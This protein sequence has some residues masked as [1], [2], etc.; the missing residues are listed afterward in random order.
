MTIRKQHRF[1]FSLVAAS[2]LLSFQAANGQ[3]RRDG[4]S[5]P[6]GPAKPITVPVTI[7]VRKSAPEVE[8]R[9]VDFL[10]RED[11]EQQTILSIRRPVENPLSLAILIQD[12]LV[13]SVGNEIRGIADFIRHQPSGS[14]IMV[15]YIR[16]GSLDVRRKFTNDAERA[17]G[18]L[19][20][21]TGSIIE[22]LRRYDSQPLG[23]R[24][25]VVVSN[26]VDVS[27]GIDGSAPGQSIDL[28][29]AIT[30]AQ[31]RGVAIYSIYAPSA[32]S[33]GNQF[34]DNNGQSCLERL[35]NETG[36]QA[37]F[38]GTGAPVSFDPFLKEIDASLGRQI[39]LTYLSTHTAKGFHRLDIKPL[40][41][42]VEIRHPAGYSR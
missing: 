23:R 38:Q 16:S 1:F 28:Q 26:G 39:A 3:E 34:L 42:D 4:S 7:R 19:R 5:R 12:D 25:I 31:R 11:G 27:R 14:R 30:E 8:M 37:F 15:G 41:R 17:A 40:E 18:G 29:R 22:A 24:A 6:R 2:L 36:G 13:S 35:S 33:S 10:L 21:P 32:A 20:I 9:I